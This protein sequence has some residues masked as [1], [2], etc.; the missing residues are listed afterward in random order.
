VTTLL[1]VEDEPLTRYALA[2]MV[3]AADPALV[4][5]EADRLEEAE[6][7]VGQADMMVVDRLL[8]DGD[9]ADWLLALRAVGNAIPAT[10]VSGNPAPDGWNTFAATWL[11]KPPER[12]AFG[13]ALAAMREAHGYLLA[14]REESSRI[15]RWNAGARRAAGMAM[16]LLVAATAAVGCGSAPSMSAAKIAEYSETFEGYAVRVE[17]VAARWQDGLTEEEAAETLPDLEVIASDLRADA[18]NIKTDAAV[19]RVEQLGAAV[20]SLP[21][22]LAKVI[23]AGL[24]L[25]A[26][27]W[28]VFGRQKKST[29]GGAR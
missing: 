26:L 5:I 11:P 3:K 8:P 7:L 23:G 20:G 21:F 17:T 27:G 16:A 13:A 12:D 22:P 4:V 6:R 28:A 2:R 1:L 18:A 14:I 25:G 19:E 9:G 10:V 15:R 24:G 29:V